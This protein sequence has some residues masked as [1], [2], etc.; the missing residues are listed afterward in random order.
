MAC[1]FICKTRWE[2][3]SVPGVRGTVSVQWTLA[4]GIFIITTVS[5][6]LLHHRQD[7]C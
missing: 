2:L 3:E 1:F 5:E 6:N 4:F 7:L